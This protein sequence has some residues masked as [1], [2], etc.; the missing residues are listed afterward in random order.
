MKFFSTFMLCL[1]LCILPGCGNNVKLNGT[2][3]FSDG[4]PLSCGT[5]CLTDG[6]H[7]YTGP[8]LAD[9]SFKLG[10]LEPGSGLPPGNYRVY[11][12]SA[13]DENGRSVVARKYESATNSGITIDVPKG[14][15]G[16][17]KITVERAAK[18]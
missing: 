8:V 4:A 14:N 13:I 10:G 16:P 15:T 5:V 12:V 2:V 17:L 3:S 11:I 18:Q 7:Q 1:G 9:G 6:L